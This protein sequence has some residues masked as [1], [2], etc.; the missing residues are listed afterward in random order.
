MPLDWTA[1]GVFIL[2]FALITVLGFMAGRWRR[3]DLDLIHE[4]GLGGSRDLTATLGER[5]AP[6]KRG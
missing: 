5:K 3:G 6:P 4:W 2:L 1:L